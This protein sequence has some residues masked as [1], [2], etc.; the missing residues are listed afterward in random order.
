[1][2]SILKMTWMQ[3]KLSAR[4]R[5]AFFFTFIFPMVFFFVYFGLFARSQPQ[6][7]AMLFGPLISFVVISSSLF[8]LSVQLVVMRE[9][10]MLRRYHLAPISAGEMVI[11]RLLGNYFLFLPVIVLQY[12]LAVWIYHMPVQGSVFGLWLLFTLGYLALSGIGLV[13]AG[14]VNTMQDAQ[15]FNQILFFILMFL[16]GTTI[17]LYELP[18]FIQHLALVF[19]PTLMI[20]AS[21]GMMAQ[22][23]SLARHWP[24]IIG[25]ALTMV[26]SLSVAIALFRWEKEEKA[27]RRS[28]IQAALAL[29]PLIAVGLWLNYSSSFLRQNRAMFHAMGARTAAHAR[30]KHR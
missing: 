21:E 13:V 28:R 16:S 2:Q 5:I 26:T 20:V 17:P 7:V 22:G 10:D 1:M 12:V 23:Q 29:I 14:I 6:V 25:L 9:R 30:N 8:G 24:E 18:K 4:V 11:S 15:V 3:V 19:P 27:T